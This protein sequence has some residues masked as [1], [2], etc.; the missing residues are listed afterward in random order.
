MFNIFKNKKAEMVKYWKTQDAVEAK[1]VQSKEGHMEMHMKGE[2]YP[3]PGFPRG[4]LLFG[5]LSPL[6]H[7]IKNKIFNDAWAL[8]EQGKTNEEVRA[9]IDEAWKSIFVMAEKTKYDM[10]PF[11]KMVPPIKELWRA[12]TAISGGRKDVLQIRDILCFIFQE[13]DAYRMRFQW[14]AKF[15]P[16]FWKPTYDNFIYSLEMLEHAEVVGDMKERIRLL[17]RVLNVIFEDS[18]LFDRFLREVNWSKIRL[19]KAD[20]YFFRAK[21]FKVDYPENQY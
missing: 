17:R 14:L 8:L 5:A 10:V 19:T 15:Y 7:N 2:K 18:A 21:Y 20:K 11:E 12:M 1:V 3:F 16:T 9:A 4:S 13:D 6:K